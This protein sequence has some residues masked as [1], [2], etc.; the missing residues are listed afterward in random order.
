MISLQD[1]Y[2]TELGKYNL[3]TSSQK[4]DEDIM[5]AIRRSV[6]VIN[7]SRVGLS[8]N[9]P[10]NMQDDLNIDEKY[11]DLVIDLVDLYLQ[12]RGNWGSQEAAELRAKANVSIARAH[13]WVSEDA[14]PDTRMGTIS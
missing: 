1:V 7:S 2:K 10:L 3:T 4:F 14:A 6:N 11:Y 8:C 5:Y 12:D 13:T 9:N